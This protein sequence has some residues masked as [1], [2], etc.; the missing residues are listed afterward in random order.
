MMLRFCTINLTVG[1]LKEFQTRFERL[2]LKLPLY[3]NSLYFL[4]CS[5]FKG[6][7]PRISQMYFFIFIFDPLQSFLWHVRRTSISKT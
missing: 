6:F 3:K 2:F 1:L 7:K 4:I 5:I